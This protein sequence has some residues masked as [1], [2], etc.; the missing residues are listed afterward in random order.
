MRARRWSHLGACLV[1]LFVAGACS[2][3]QGQ[4]AEDAEDAGPPASATATSS[5]APVAPS[6]PF[7]LVDDLS[8]A[9]ARAR[10]EHRPLMLVFTAQWNGA[11][12]LFERG[13][14]GDSAV[15]E[16]ARRFVAAR[17]DYTEETDAQTEVLARYNVV[18]VPTVILFDSD[19]EEA[20]RLSRYVKPAEFLAAIAPIH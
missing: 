20:L 7:E 1:V 14:L 2:T 4:D 6:P 18:S 12:E 9:K 15:K 8:E 19:G 10:A 3:K 13:T 11:S 5:T 16:A 17:A